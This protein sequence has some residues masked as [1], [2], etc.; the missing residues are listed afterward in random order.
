MAIQDVIITTN[1]FVCPSGVESSSTPLGL[2]MFFLKQSLNYF[3]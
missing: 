3:T 1:Y 2:T